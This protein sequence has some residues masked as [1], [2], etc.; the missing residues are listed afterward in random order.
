MS[1]TMFKDNTNYFE[2]RFEYPEYINV[3]N[4]FPVD[5]TVKPDYGLSF[6][7]DYYGGSIENPLKNNFFANLFNDNLF[8]EVNSYIKKRLEIYNQYIK[9][10]DLKNYEINYGNLAIRI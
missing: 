4:K 1:E 3:F 10:N 6:K 5:T 7:P 2:N 8:N 9:K